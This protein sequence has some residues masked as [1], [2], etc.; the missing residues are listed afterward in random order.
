MTQLIETQEET[1]ND[2]ENQLEFTDN[3]VNKGKNELLKYNELI[4]SNRG[5]ILKIFA[6]LLFILFAFSFYR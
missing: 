3:E 1:I 4:F 6:V 2:L 5:L